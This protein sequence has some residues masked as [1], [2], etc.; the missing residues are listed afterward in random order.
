MN[1]YAQIYFDEFHKRASGI[2]GVAVPEL[3]PIAASKTT[4]NKD[5]EQSVGDVRQFTAMRSK[6]QNQN[7]TM[8]EKG[9]EITNKIKED[10]AK[11]DAS[12]GDPQYRA[13]LNASLQ[14]TKP[15]SAMP[16]G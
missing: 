7:T 13:A 8:G 10:A 12:G 1:K 3:A 14:K 5:L 15:V 9:T 2:G 11:D 16:G 6:V 4:H